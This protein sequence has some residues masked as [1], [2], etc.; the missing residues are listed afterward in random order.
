MISLY[1]IAYLSNLTLLGMYR[2]EGSIGITS[3]KGK[4]RVCKS[5]PPNSERWLSC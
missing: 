3:G 2:T 4:G 5:T 1:V